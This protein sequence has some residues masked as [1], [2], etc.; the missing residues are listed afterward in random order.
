MH[1]SKLIT[2]LKVFSSEERELLKKW[3][4]SPALTS[5]TKIRALLL[6]LLSKRKLTA[7][8][9]KKEYLFEQLY[10][11]EVY[12][13]LKWRHLI[14]Q[15]VNNLEKFVHFLAH[16]KQTFEQRKHL[17]AFYRGRKLD[18]YAQQHLQKA[19]QE[20][21]EVVLRNAHYFYQQYQLEQEIFEQEGT[22]KRMRQTNLQA[23]FDKH[24]ITF[25]LETLRHACTA[26]TH[27]NLYKS[28]YE[29]PLLEEV[30]VELKTGVYNHIPAVELYYKSYMAL[31]EPDCE[32]HFQQLKGLLLK[33]GHVLSFREQKSIYVIAINYCVRRLNTGGEAYVEAVFELFKYGLEHKILLEQGKLSRFTYKNIVTAA[34]RL[35]EYVWAEQFIETYTELIDE[36]YQSSYAHYAKAKLLFAQGAFEDTLSLLS[37]LEYDDLFLNMDA[38]LMFLKIY[39]ELGYWD[40]LEALLVSFRRFL[41]RKSII[42]YQKSIYENIINLTEKLIQ[43]PN[44]EM[45]KLAALETEINQA[46]PLTEKP[47]LLLQLYKK[48]KKSPNRS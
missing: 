43:I 13:D 11:E 41:Q 7:R 26:I 45:E 6:L 46:Y 12:D 35:Q 21:E 1:K 42:A 23:I 24:Y 9:C 14:N 37:Q 20:Q 17:I 3:V 33:Q 18:K 10:P 22:D 28:T 32:T 19:A 40:A 34:A 36:V 25:V 29:I 38:K 48:Y 4:K 30:L 16:K 27:Q 8:T 47:W 31:R 2:I 39:Y 44:Y 5:H 15:A